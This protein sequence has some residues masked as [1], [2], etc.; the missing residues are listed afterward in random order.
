MVAIPS[1]SLE[2]GIQAAE[3]VANKS[4]D[5]VKPQLKG[6]GQQIAN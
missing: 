4:I 1:V 5:N 6:K 3:K 2:Q